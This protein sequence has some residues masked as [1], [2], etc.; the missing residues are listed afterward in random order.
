MAAEASSITLE[1][2][3]GDR[4]VRLSWDRDAAES[5]AAEGDDGPARSAWRTEEEPDWEHAEALRLVS[6]VFE[7]GRTV[8]LAAL[9][10]KGATG[11]DRDL[12]AHCLET[13]G[14]PVTI[15]EA[16]LSTEY[17]ADGVPRRIGLEL[18]VEPDSPPLRLA[19]DRRGEAEVSGDGTRR[20]LL[21]MSYRLDGVAGVGTYELLRPA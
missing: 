10:P 11:H 9:R 15:T 13:T 1:L 4:P 8:V 3:A 5:L 2:P 18:W 16:L 17:D 20:E 7:D 6:A 12:V 21:A 14:E 19:G